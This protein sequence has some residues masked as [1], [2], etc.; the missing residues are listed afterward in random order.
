MGVYI[1]PVDCT[2]EQWLADNAKPSSRYNFNR[3]KFCE[4]VRYVFLIDN[5]TFTAALVV[6]DQQEWDYMLVNLLREDRRYTV[7]TVETSK[8]EG[9]VTGRP[10]RVD[11]PG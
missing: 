3:D 11:T 1:N 8:L 9:V 7:Y 6:D 4:E 5:G 10:K 2:K